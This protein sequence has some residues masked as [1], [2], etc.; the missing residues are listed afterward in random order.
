M[1]SGS[2]ETTEK[3]NAIHLAR[4]I[5]ISSG[6][7]VVKP[8]EISQLTQEW[9][10]T[11]YMMAIDMPKAKAAKQK[12]KSLVDEIKRKHPTFGKRFKG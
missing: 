7:V 4:L 1:A 2:A 9:V 6:G 12:T 3:I 10:D 5:N 8:W 11:F